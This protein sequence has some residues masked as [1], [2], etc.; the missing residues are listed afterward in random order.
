MFRLYETLIIMNN[1]VKKF[2][3]FFVFN[4]LQ[5]TSLP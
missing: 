3:I 5:G 4:I 1:I 2:L